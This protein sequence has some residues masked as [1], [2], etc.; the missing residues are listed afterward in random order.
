MPVSVSLKLLNSSIKRHIVPFGLSG[1]TFER[2]LL[3]HLLK[4]VLYTN[5]IDLF[6]A[7][8]VNFFTIPDVSLFLRKKLNTGGTIEPILL[9]TEI[10]AISLVLN[11]IPCLSYQ[12]WRNSDLILAMSTLEGHSDLHPLHP[13][14]R[15]SISY[16]SLWFHGSPSLLKNSR[17]TFAL[18]RVLL[19][20]SPVAIKLGHIV[21]PIIAD[22]RQSAVP[23]HLSAALII[24]SLE[25][26]S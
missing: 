24:P 9:I 26:K 19:N 6:D 1:L 5:G 21:P 20:S 4:V 22:F 7:N 23:L 13:K 11:G 18:A 3:I 12:C 14:Q 8:P 15:S 2:F 16:I 25:E 17:T 10:Y